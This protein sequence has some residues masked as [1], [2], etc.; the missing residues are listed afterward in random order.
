M[1]P[2]AIANDGYLAAAEP[3]V[4]GTIAPVAGI[5]QYTGVSITFR[6]KDVATDWDVI[7]RT[8]N[9]KATVYLSVL[10][11][12]NAN[13][14]EA[15]ATLSEAGKVILE[16]HGLATNGSQNWQLFLGSLCE[17]GECVA[18]ISYNV[19]GSVAF[20]RDGELMLTYAANTA[21]G[22]AGTV[23]K[24]LSPAMIAQVRTQGLSVVYPVSNVIIA[25]AADYDEEQG[26]ARKRAHRRRSARTT[27]TALIR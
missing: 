1:L 26:A 22:T 17:G 3:A 18:T 8:P 9:A 15:S 25:Y 10:N 11:Y 5:S 6:V 14:F 24:T 4:G 2:D 19:D 20:Y 27:A 21:I 16:E 7:F 13:T 12:N 23:R